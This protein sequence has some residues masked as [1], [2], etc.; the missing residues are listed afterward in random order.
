MR[1]MFKIITMGMLVAAVLPAMAKE[2]WARLMKFIR[3]SV[4]DSPHASTNSNMP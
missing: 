3:P 4:T 1:G 2:P